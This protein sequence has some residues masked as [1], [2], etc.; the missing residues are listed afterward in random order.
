ME[1]KGE[2]GERGV[3]RDRGGL[4]CIQEDKRMDE[5]TSA[6]E[7]HDQQQWSKSQGRTVCKPHHGN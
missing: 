4:A 6:E 5:E 2:R 7:R 3:E 1:K